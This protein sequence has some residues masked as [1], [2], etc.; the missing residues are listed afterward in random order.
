M[1]GEEREWIECGS[2]GEDSKSYRRGIM[3]ISLK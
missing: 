1:S 3:G 2:A